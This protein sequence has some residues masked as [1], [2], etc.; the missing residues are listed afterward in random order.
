MPFSF[1][2]ICDLLQS[3]E[4][5]LSRKKRPKGSSKIV[6]EWFAGHRNVL[7]GANVDQTALLST[8][9]PERRTDRVY[10]IQHTRLESIV[11]KACGLGRSRQSAL[12]R[13]REQGSGTDLAECVE[14]ILEA[15]P[16]G[17]TRDIT[18]EEVDGVLHQLAAW[19]AFSSPAVRSSLSSVSLQSKIAS[20]Q[21][22]RLE[23]LFRQLTPRD[24]KWLCRLVLKNFLP[25]VVPEHL[26]YAQCHPLLPTILK[27]HNDF[28]VAISLLEQQV[29]NDSGMRLDLDEADIPRLIKPKV[30]VKVGRQTWL[31]VRSIQQCISMGHGLMSCEEK[32]DGEY[33]QVHIDLVGPRR[34]Q[35]FSKSGKDS[36]ADRVNLH[37]AIRSSL[38]LGS[39]KCRFKNNCILE[40]ELVVWSDTEK[41]I[42]GFEEIRRHVSR[43]G[44]F[45]GTA[46]AGRPPASERLMIVYYDLL[47]VD[48]QSLLNV[49][50]FERCRRLAALAKCE[51]GRSAL[52]QRTIINFSSR[53]A[54]LELRE[55]FATCIVQRQ[56]GLVL[57]SD[58]PYFDFETNKSRHGSCV[59]KLK[60]AYLKNLG[61]VGDLAVVGARYDSTA[62]KVLALPN[63]QYTHFY[64]GC[65]INKDEVT[66]FEHAKPAF[67][68]V[69]EV[70]LN[71][72]MAAYFQQYVFTR[73]VEPAQNTE[74]DLH[75]SQG[76]VQGR[77]LSVVFLD[78]A[79]FEITCF[80]FHHDTNSDFWSPRFPYVSKIHADRSWKDCLGFEELQKIASTEQG[81]P[82]Y[83]DSQELAQWIKALEKIEPRRIENAVEQDSGN[84]HDSCTTGLSWDDAWPR[85]ASQQ[86][87]V[88]AATCEVGHIA[89]NAVSNPPDSPTAQAPTPELKCCGNGS[90]SVVGLSARKRGREA[91]PVSPPVPRQKRHTS[92]HLVVQGSHPDSPL[93][94]SYRS[95][96]QVTPRVLSESEQLPSAI[97]QGTNTRRLRN[98]SEPLTS[99]VS[100]SSLPLGKS[101][102]RRNN[103]S[104]PVD[105]SSGGPLRAVPG[106]DLKLTKHASLICCYAGESCALHGCTVL[107]APCVAHFPWLTDDLLPSHGIAAVFKDVASWLASAAT[108]P[109]PARRQPRVVLVE[110]RRSEATK[111]FLASLQAEPLKDREGKRQ[112][113]IVYDWHLL[114][115]ITHAEKVHRRSSMSSA[116]QKTG[117]G[118]LAKELWRKHYIGLC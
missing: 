106:L 92:S 101:A 57:K 67:I 13:W 102:A 85:I 81:C 65:A 17:A 115:D 41:R 112:I 10:N 74:Y 89:S 97:S 64:V 62:A 43:S 24:A 11:S 95:L 48:N 87:T 98:A 58:S 7:V 29:C 28:A 40:G 72:T 75:L 90:G 100:F 22:L 103:T 37:S 15:A 82:E 3:L 111:K 2:A 105:L 32:V 118:A 61:E 20:R 34:I 44:R 114:E 117:T 19:S 59:L 14:A 30:G 73:S 42:L 1:G 94:E 71:A 86:A 83:A 109:S 36:T 26:V 96:G 66:R 116:R 45:M 33:C 18:V 80:A 104:E 91:F 49:R 84:T 76:I 55:A 54:A 79:V 113:L 5:D 51:E 108:L 8:L 12:A 52:V 46:I 27:I 99:P 38:D 60:K 21:Q 69:A 4:T 50:Y 31:K 110:R 25:V 9:L 53:L 6:I 39:A 23:D 107:L 35:I 93:R 77:Q 63:I 16:N 68:I 88:L 70:E 47:S 78:P 56:E